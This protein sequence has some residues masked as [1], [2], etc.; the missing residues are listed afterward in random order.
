VRA[1]RAPFLYIGSRSDYRAPLQE[2]RTIVRTAGSR[3]KRSIFY[4]GSRPGWELVQT[5][6]FARK[7][8]TLSTDTRRLNSPAIED[9]G[10]QVIWV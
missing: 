7:T 3:D 4:R 5:A 6:P 2:A 10:V 9:W 1:L 8:R